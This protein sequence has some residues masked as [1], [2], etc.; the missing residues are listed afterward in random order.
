VKLES[1]IQGNKRTLDKADHITIP[2]SNI[3][4]L[5]YLIFM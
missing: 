4:D 2:Q 5:L 3:G 1:Q